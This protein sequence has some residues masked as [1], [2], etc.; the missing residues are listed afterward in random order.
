MNQAGLV[1]LGKALRELRKLHHLSQQEVA[2]RLGL[3]QTEVSQLELGQVK[4]PSLYRLCAFARLYGVT[5]TDLAVLA[6]WWDRRE[7]EEDPHWSLLRDTI[8]TVPLQYREEVL[9]RL[10]LYA[11]TQVYLFEAKEQQQ[12][13]VHPVTAGQA[14]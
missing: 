3:Q 12:S 10:L 11:K 7:A 2:D 4:N 1:V 14:S 8:R 6:G 5:P 9:E 13:T